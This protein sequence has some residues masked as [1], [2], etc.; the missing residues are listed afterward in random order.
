MWFSMQQFEIDHIFC[1]SQVIEK[2]WEYNEEIHP[3]F[4]D[5]NKAHDSVRKLSII[6]DSH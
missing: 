2:N 3:P 5:F 6:Y 4:T 1:I